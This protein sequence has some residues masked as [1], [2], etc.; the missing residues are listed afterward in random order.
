MSSILSVGQSALAAAQIGLQVTSNNIANANTPGF[1]RETIIQAEAGGQN[2]GNGFLGSGAEVQT[3]QRQYNAFLAIQQNGA[4]SAYSSLNTNY[5]QIS[6]INN[7]FASTTT[8]LSPA[9]QSF[10]NS[11][12]TANSDPSASSSR[13]AILTAA[14]ALASQFQ[15]SSQQLQQ[16]GQ[17]V[18]T[19]IETTV[20]SINNYA[21]Q[22]A[23]L[24][25]SIQNAEAGNAGQP[26]NDLLDQRDQAVANLS[27]LV[28]VTV[29]DEGAAGYNI[30][31]GNG[32]P[33]VVGTK[34]YQLTTMQSPTNVSQLE[35]G[36]V[37]PCGTN[38][39]PEN[40]LTGGSLGGLMQFRSQSLIPAENTIGQLA[41]GVA[42]TVNAQQELGQDLNGNPGVA[43]FS[44]GSPTA[45]SN[46]NNTGNL[47]VGA[48]I[49][50]TKVLTNS[51]YTLQFDGAK[52]NLTRQ[53][54]NK[55]VYSGATFPPAAAIDGLTFTA[56][57]TPATG[58]NFLI[59][60]TA[61]GASQF[62]LT[63][64]NTSQIAMAAPIVTNAP[65]SNTGTGVISAGTVNPLANPVGA[66][67]PVYGS[68]GV[69]ATA[70]YPNLQ[71]NV[72]I[73]FNGAPNAGTYTVTDNTTGAV[74]GSNVAYVAGQAITFNGWSVNITGSPAANDKFTIGP[75][76]SGSGDSR[77]GVLMA[78]LQTSKTLDNGTNS[79]QSA[80]AQMVSTVGNQA[81]ELQA[82]SQAANTTLTNA[83]NA[84]QAVSGVNL[85]EEASNLIKYQEAYQAAGKLMSTISSLFS[86]LL[87][88][89]G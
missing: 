51:N 59:Q 7:M 42:D 38:E 82:T 35:V 25:Q 6:Q 58:D 3:V 67:T 14:Q 86:S 69:P 77:N 68:N 21:T 76:T 26:P 55:I 28:G 22:I 27:Q 71:D 46:T 1:N 19:Q 56:T 45:T 10:F 32:Q 31:I 79:I 44:T 36:Y 85:D 61:S 66:S 60:P 73:Q 37:T 49:T 17:G 15:S 8:G 64:T 54:D 40:S 11:V 5:T 81:A 20:S 12:Q 89:L 70:A 4:Q 39:I 80:Y 41:I 2:L 13:E 52:Y 48:T 75:N 87:T 84:Q 62:A 9:I 18:N 30:N 57:G 74:L 23:S 50:D 29:V 72:T 24:N 34:Q 78:A 43:M 16:I 83:T 47:T 88:E 65:N 63:L 33:L 53:S